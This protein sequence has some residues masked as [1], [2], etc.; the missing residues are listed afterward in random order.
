MFKFSLSPNHM[1]HMYLAWAWIIIKTTDPIHSGLLQVLH[2]SH[3]CAA[4]EL[5]STQG[6]I[7]SCR[8]RAVGSSPVT[9]ISFY[10]SFKTRKENWK[11]KPIFP[12]IYTTGFMSSLLGVIPMPIIINQFVICGKFPSCGVSVITHRLTDRRKLRHIGLEK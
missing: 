3:P 1:H 11:L 5:S 12:Y 8:W 4:L 2:V 10:I 6:P 7:H 9:L